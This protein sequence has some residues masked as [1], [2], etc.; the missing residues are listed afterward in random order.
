[1]KIQAAV[2]REPRGRLS[3]EEIDLAEPGA[4]EVRVRIAASGLCHTD[5][6]TM[7]GTQPSPAILGRIR[8]GAGLVRLPPLQFGVSEVVVSALI[9]RI[10]LDDPRRA[11]LCVSG[12][13]GQQVQ[14]R[15]AGAG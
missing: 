14:S 5:W 7:R 6:E 10:E 15:S 13:R 2:L 12:L 8:R 1:M 9:A 11:G 3:V 4:G